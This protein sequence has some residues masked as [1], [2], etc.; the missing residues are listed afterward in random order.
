MV[1]VLSVFGREAPPPA[2]V[3]AAAPVADAGAPIQVL[4][5]LNTA[6]V[7]VTPA[8]VPSMP[9]AP[10]GRPAVMRAFARER[11]NAVLPEAAPDAGAP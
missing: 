8:A 5:P 2:P 3:Q 10:E 1:V 4:T 11:S 6:P 9:S 7:V